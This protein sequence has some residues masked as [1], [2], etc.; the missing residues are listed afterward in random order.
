MHVSLVQTGIEKISEARPDFDLGDAGPIADNLYAQIQMQPLGT[1]PEEIRLQ[2]ELTTDP[3][4]G[5][6]LAL[7]PGQ[8]TNG[9]QVPTTGAGG[10]SGPPPS[11]A[12]R[13]YF[14]ELSGRV[15]RGQPLEYATRELLAANPDDEVEIARAYH[16]MLERTA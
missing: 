7:P 14:R 3:E 1:T 9:P 16:Q 4:T 10:G 15:G 11:V 6:P 8:S 12:G 13:K 5:K 2:G